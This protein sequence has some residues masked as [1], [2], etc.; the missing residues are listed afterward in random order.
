MRTLA[1]MME[2]IARLDPSIIAESFAFYMAEESR[3]RIIRFLI[4]RSRNRLDPQP[5]DGD[6]E[7]ANYSS[8]VTLHVQTRELR[9]RETAISLDLAKLTA[10]ASAYLSN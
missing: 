7:T 8:V 1:E 4:R 2:M 10:H 9:A 3:V 6:L 5:A